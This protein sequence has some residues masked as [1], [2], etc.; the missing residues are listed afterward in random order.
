MIAALNNFQLP[1][2][3]FTADAINQPVIA[4]DAPG[5]KPLQGIFKGLR[6]PEPLERIALDID[7]TWLFWTKR[8][9]RI[10][11]KGA[12]HAEEEVQRGADCDA[13]SPD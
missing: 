13:A 3:A 4:R 11:W 10:A 1:L 7:L 12:G 9:E 5:P 6:F 8:C 2:F